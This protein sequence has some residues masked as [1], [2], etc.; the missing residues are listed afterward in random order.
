METFSKQPGEDLDYDFDYADFLQAGETL[1]SAVVTVSDGINN[2]AN[3]V[4]ASAVKVWLTGG[5]SGQIYKITCLA[6]TST[7]PPR[8]KE[9]EFRLRVRE[10]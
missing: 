9:Q 3:V 6:T 5:T 8:K 2:L 10:L 4:S 7:S 1:V